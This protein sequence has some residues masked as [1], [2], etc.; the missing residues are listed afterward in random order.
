MSRPNMMVADEM[1]TR[2]GCV[3]CTKDAYWLLR[4]TLFFIIL[5]HWVYRQL[6]FLLG[7]GGGTGNNFYKFGSD[8]S[9]SGSVVGDSEL[10]NHLCG[11]LGSVIHSR[12]PGKGEGRVNGFG[13]R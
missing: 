7:G 8:D 13:Q 1:V 10:I 11:V 5:R 6:A 9:L 12:H 3:L 2:V 4:T